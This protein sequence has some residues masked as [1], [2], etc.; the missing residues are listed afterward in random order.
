VVFVIVVIFVPERDAVA[1]LEP[2]ARRNSAK[3]C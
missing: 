2:N 1:R 3:A